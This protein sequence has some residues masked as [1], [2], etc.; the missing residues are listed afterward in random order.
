[1]TSNTSGSG[2]VWS[3]SSAYGS[4]GSFGDESGDGGSVGRGSNG[5]GSV[6]DHGFSLGDINEDDYDRIWN[7]LPSQASRGFNSQTSPNFGSF[8]SESHKTSFSSLLDMNT[9][10]FSGPSSGNVLECLTFFN[11]TRSNDGKISVTGESINLSCLCII[12]GE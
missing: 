11:K 7:I 3:D 6:G 8:D 5:G 9:H 4:H 12:I 10:R 1:M 2:H